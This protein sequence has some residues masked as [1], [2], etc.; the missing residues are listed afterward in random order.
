MAARRRPASPSTRALVR[1]LR[2]QGRSVS[3]IVA[4]LAQLGQ[5]VSRSAVG[6]LVGPPAPARAPRPR[7]SP[8]TRLAAAARRLA[9][10][11]GDAVA[12]LEAA[13]LELRQAATV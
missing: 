7:S 10:P 3:A 12:L 1:E 2:R 11:E 6:R 4:A 13:A 5:V 8:K 9:G